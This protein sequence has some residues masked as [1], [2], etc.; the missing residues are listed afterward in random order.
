M[1]TIYGEKSIGNINTYRQKIINSEYGYSPRNHEAYVV[2]AGRVVGSILR[3]MAKITYIT[4]L[5]DN[6][7][8]LFFL[9]L[10]ILPIFL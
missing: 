5:A 3:F 10:F 4:H 1:V 7:C 9:C 6:V 8:R 2:L